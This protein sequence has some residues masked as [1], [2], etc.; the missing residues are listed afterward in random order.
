MQVFDP[1]SQTKPFAQSEDDAHWL[2][3][4]PNAGSQRYGAQSK[5]TDSLTGHVAPGAVQYAGPT[6]CVGPTQRLR[7]HIVPAPAPMHAP[8]G[9][10][11][12]RQVLAGPHSFFRS[13][14]VGSSV[15]LPGLVRSPHEWQ[16]SPHAESQ[17]TPSTQKPLVQSEGFVQRVKSETVGVLGSVGAGASAIGTEPLSGTPPSHA[18]MHAPPLQAPLTQSSDVVH[19][20]LHV[21]ASAHFKPLGHAVTEPGLQVLSTP[22]QVPR[23][24]VA[25]PTQPARPHD[26][27]EGFAVQ[28][29][30]EHASHSPLHARSQ[31]TPAAHVPLAHSFVLPHAAP[32]LFFA[33]QA[34]S[35]Q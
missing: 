34:P 20:V 30:V 12:P 1:I 15:H 7:P 16:R 23:V 25:A 8:P 11:V 13:T 18:L 27:V 22:E 2:R 14:P 29:P 31:H 5:G 28:V 26:S 17:H 3:H 35:R 6:P 19:V 9:P 10:H 32:L 24:M 33:T 21:V 4:A